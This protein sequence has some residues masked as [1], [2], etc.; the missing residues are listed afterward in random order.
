MPSWIENEPGRPPANVRFGRVW[1]AHAFVSSRFIAVQQMSLDSMRGNGLRQFAP[2]RAP[3]PANRKVRWG[4]P[5]KAGLP[6]C[7][8]SHNVYQTI[9]K[10]DQS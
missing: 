5:E 2:R 4:K 8:N 10:R 9:K 1:S 7:G 3:L 6:G